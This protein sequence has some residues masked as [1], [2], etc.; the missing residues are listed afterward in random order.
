MSSEQHRAAEVNRRLTVG[1]VECF[2][3]SDGSFAYADPGRAF[4]ANADR[5]EL[6][7][8]LDRHG[9]DADAWEAYVSPYPC[10]VVRTHD[11]TVLVDTGAGDELGDHTGKL[12]ANLEAAGIDA[13][14]VDTVL[15]THIH[16]DHVGGNL[17][18]EGTEAF[19]NAEYLVSDTEFEFWSTDPDLSSLQVPEHVRGAMVAAAE[20]QVRPL[21]EDLRLLPDASTEIAPGVR[22]I[23][24]PGHTPGHLAVEVRSAGESLRHLVDLVLLPVHVEHPEWCAAFD[25]DPETLV[26][27]R[28]RL[29]GRA[30]DE[31]SL[32]LVHHFPAP[33]LGRV[34]RTDAGFEW[35]P[36]SKAV[37]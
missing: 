9:V 12:R 22:T 5:T 2:V 32:V 35:E 33:G 10:L 36:L 34:R 15:L 11:R 27:S 4:F 25:I 26:A 30:A 8:A 28:R 14:D 37:E 3:V 1:E 21:A 7:A 24:A 16:P 20:E 31:G 23:P 19:P 6:A 29:L 18:D 17:T 13:A